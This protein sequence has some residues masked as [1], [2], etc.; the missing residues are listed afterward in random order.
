MFAKLASLELRLYSENMFKVGL[1]LVVVK[2]ERFILSPRLSTNV[3]TDKSALILAI[4]PVEPALL[5][6]A[7]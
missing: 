3:T 1:P 6:T 7:S 4:T 5:L 2:L